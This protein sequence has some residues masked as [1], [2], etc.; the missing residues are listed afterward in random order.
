[1]KIWLITDTHF[2]HEKLTEIGERPPDFTELIV[3][4]W[5]RLVSPEDLVIHLGDVALGK[6][7]A[8]KDLLLSLPGRLWLVLGNH[9]HESVSWYMDNRFSMV[10]QSVVFRNAL[11][12]HAPA[13]ELPANATINIHGHLHNNAH[14]FADYEPRPFHRLLAIEDHKY[15]PVLWERFV[16]QEPMIQL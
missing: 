14:R 1:M 11:L 8:L 6:K 15:E 12:T 13:N 5:Q 7:P 9:D 4:N 16:G 3:R 2:F 10:C